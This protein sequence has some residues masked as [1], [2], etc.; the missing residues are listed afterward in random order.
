MVLLDAAS[1]LCRRCSSSCRLRRRRC[2]L[3]WC[4][5]RISSQRQSCLRATRES[6]RLFDVSF[7]KHA[8]CHFHHHLDACLLIP[9]DF[10]NADVVFAIPCGGQL[11]HGYSSSTML[12][13]DQEL[14]LSF[15]IEYNQGTAKLAGVE[16]VGCSIDHSRYVLWALLYQFLIGAAPPKRDTPMH[17]AGRSGSLESRCPVRLPLPTVLRVFI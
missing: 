8:Y 17:K 3:P 15:E 9:V 7:Q 6:L 16:V 12:V 5:C 13:D 2:C 10:I 14:L 4:S 1:P 11:R